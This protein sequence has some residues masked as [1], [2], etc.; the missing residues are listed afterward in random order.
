MDEVE[1]GN[2]VGSL[3]CQLESAVEGGVLQENA[4]IVVRPIFVW[5]NGTLRVWV[6]INWPN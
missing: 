1:F 2:L 6:M 4:Q 3:M 5:P